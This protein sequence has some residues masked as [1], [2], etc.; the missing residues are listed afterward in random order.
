MVNSK[1]V[2]AIVAVACL[3]L[4]PATRAQE[5]SDKSAQSAPPSVLGFDISG[6]VD[7]AYSNLS[8]RGAFNLTPGGPGVT[9][10]GP[11]R[12]FD[13]RRDALSLHQAAVTFTRQPKEGLGGVLNV[14]AGRDADAIAAY[15]TDPSNGTGCNLATGQSA[16]GGCKTD[17]FDVTQAFLHYAT[18]PFMIHAGKFV[19]SA[20]AEVIASPS[21]SNYSRSILFGYAIPFTHT[22]VRLWYTATDSLTLMAGINNGW[23]D[24][25]DTNSSKSGEFVVTFSPTKAFT[26]SAGLHNGT[27]RVGG[28][29]GTGPEGTRTL[30]DLVATF[31]VTDKL[32][33][34]LNYDNGAQNN[35]ATATANGATKAKWDGWAGYVNYQVND[36]WRVSLRGE[37]FDDRDGYRT[38]VVQKWK[39]VTLTVGYSP[40]KNL[41]LRAE[42]RA[43]RS[44]AN[45]FVDSN[46]LTAGKNQNSLALQ[47]IYKF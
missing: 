15:D 41:E 23:D 38:G 4:P 1:A 39:E 9:I 35:A 14:T 29:V 10:G 18:G 19:T 40:M 36:Q 42:A 8:G 21:N 11:N 17:R 34:V 22:G 37:Y 44:D 7:V 27:E 26:L 45:A 46:G 6:Y 20:G 28:L 3:A 24:L 12:V 47:A 32:T 16:T 2:S 33:L 13:Y 25:R 31:N 5:A 43:D 30:L